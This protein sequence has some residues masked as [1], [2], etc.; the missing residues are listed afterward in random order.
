MVVSVRQSRNVRG[1]AGEPLP[2]VWESFDRIGARF[3][4]GQLAMIAAAPG[5]GKSALALSYALQAGVRTMYFSADSDATEQ[6]GRASSILTGAPLADTKAEFIAGEIRDEVQRAPIYWSFNAQPTLDDIDEEIDALY[7]AYLWE[8][9]V[10]V[11]DNLTNVLSGFAGNEEDP[12][13]GLEALLDHLNGLARRTGACVIATHHVTG[14]HNDGVTA[15]PLS[16]L[17]GQVGRVP[18]MVLTVHKRQAVGEFSPD[19]LVVS[20]VKNRGSKSDPTG[21]M[22]AELELDGDRMQLKD[23]V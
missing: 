23:L 20:L 7:E 11:I 8:P 19:M 15:I 14:P 6:I 3:L 21:R 9:E 10:V 18:Q 17:K 13:G 5:V 2:T 4:R 22:T 1:H 12:F 16:G